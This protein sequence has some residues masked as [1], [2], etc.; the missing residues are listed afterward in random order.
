[1]KRT[2]MHWANES[3]QTCPAVVVTDV[4][5]DTGGYVLYPLFQL[6]RGERVFLAGQA[7][8]IG[9]YLETAVA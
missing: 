1:M 3:A 9:R 8:L 7:R 5:F 6:T 2:S 4:T